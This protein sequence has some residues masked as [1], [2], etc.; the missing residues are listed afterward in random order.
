MRGDA[1][2][3]SGGTSGV[4]PGVCVGEDVATPPGTCG[5]ATKSDGEGAKLPQKER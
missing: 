1:E 2:G 5:E 3:A 4:S